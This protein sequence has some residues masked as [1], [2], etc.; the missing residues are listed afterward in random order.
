TGCLAVLPGTAEL[1]SVATVICR[2]PRRLM[3]KGGMLWF[4][5]RVCAGVPAVYRIF[6][7]KGV[8]R[9]VSAIGAR[10]KRQ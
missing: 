6:Y 8:E 1:S 10:R 9:Q 4:R 2:E 3:W 7:E 5:I